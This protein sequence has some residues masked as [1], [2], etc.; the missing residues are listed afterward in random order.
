MPRIALVNHSKAGSYK[1]SSLH[2]CNKRKTLVKAGQTYTRARTGTCSCCRLLTHQVSCGSLFF[3]C[4]LRFL[5]LLTLCN[6]EC[7][8]QFLDVLYF[9]WTPKN[10]APGCSVWSCVCVLQSLKSQV[11]PIFSMLEPIGRVC[12]WPLSVTS[13]TLK[14][15]NKIMV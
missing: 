9:V 13:S 8:N 7:G 14:I 15:K 10:A 4:Y 5:P 6:N 2:L 1:I 12:C 3:Y 11:F